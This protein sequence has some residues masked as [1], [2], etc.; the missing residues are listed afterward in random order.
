MLNKITNEFLFMLNNETDWMDKT[1]KDQ[2]SSKLNMMRNFIGYHDMLF[3]ST[4]MNKL[5]NV[6]KFY[7]NN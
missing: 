4:Y 2:V 1:S 3:N 5:H 7:L 6:I